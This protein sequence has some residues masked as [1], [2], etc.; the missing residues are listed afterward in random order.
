V[1]ERP[2]PELEHPLGLVLEARDLLDGLTR[3][4]A[5]GLAQIDD[6]VV[7]GEL[8]TLVGDDVTGGGHA[9]LVPGNIGAL[10]RRNLD[11][12]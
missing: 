5:L 2:K 4:P 8:L 10:G 9:V 6:V 7:E 12:W 11:V 1:F 3:Q